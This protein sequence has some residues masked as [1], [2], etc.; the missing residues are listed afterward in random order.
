MKQGAQSFYVMDDL[1]QEA[2][3]QAASYIGT[4]AAMITNSASAAIVLAVS[5]LLTRDNTRLIHDV[6]ARE[7]LPQKDVIVMTGH[8]IDYGAPVTTM[9]QLAGAEI[10]FAGYA[11]GCTQKQI[12]EAISDKTIAM[13]YVRSH[14][15]VQKNMPELAEVSQL[16]NQHNIP[17]IVDAA[18]ETNITAFHDVADMLIISGS[19]AIEGPTSGILAG[20]Q[21]YIEYA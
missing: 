1:R 13:V 2:G 21:T 3:K 11:N 6:Q 16:L 9:I 17:L 12:E 5:G 19:K 15:C 10:T 18:A 8:D 14:H 4:E 20:R 7:C